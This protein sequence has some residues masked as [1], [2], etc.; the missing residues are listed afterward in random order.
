[1]RY[2][3]FMASSVS[4]SFLMQRAARAKRMDERRVMPTPTQL[5]M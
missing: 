3:R 2:C 4:L 5:T 1:M